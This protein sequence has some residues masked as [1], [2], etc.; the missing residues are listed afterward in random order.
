MTL[1]VRSHQSAVRIVVFEERN[2]RR[3]DGDDLLRRNVHVVD[4]I[5]RHENRL[6]IVTCRD[7]L[8]DKPAVFV[9]RFVRLRD[10]DLVLLVCRQVAHVVRHAVRR[11]VHLAVR[12]FHEAKLVDARVIRQR[13]DEA[14]VRTFRRLD[15]A[16]ASVVRVVDVSHLEAC[17]LAREAAG[18]ER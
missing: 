13:T 4:A 15:R 9:E 1:H 6:L 5:T 14:D 16:H 7:A 12:S 10:D 8:V 2:H 11:L 18:A 17:A 3:G